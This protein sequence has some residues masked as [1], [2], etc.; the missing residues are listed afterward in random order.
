MKDGHISLR[1]L[2]EVSL[3]E[4]DLL[5]ELANN[6]EHCYGS[7]LSGAGFG[8]CTVSLV[9]EKNAHEFIEKI[10]NEYFKSTGIVSDI[11][12]CKARDGVRVEWRKIN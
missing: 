11:Y 10:K 4:L 9:K 8:G 5:V 3:P 2:Y 6:F 1:D 12:V 7:R